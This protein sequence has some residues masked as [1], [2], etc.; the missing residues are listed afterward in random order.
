[1]GIPR[2]P[3]CDHVEID[4]VCTTKPIEWI[5]PAEPG[6]RVKISLG[7]VE[8]GHELSEYWFQPDGIDRDYIE[9]K[10]KTKVVPIAQYE[11]LDAIDLE[12]IGYYQSQ[13]EPWY[14]ANDNDLRGFLTSRMTGGTA[15]CIY[16]LKYGR[17]PS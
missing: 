8:P 14:E 9:L 6:H 1:M 5:P 12:N 3:E 13:V 16:V 15:P 10:N 7:Y 11:P 2:I 4:S 17:R